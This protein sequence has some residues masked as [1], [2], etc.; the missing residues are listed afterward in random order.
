S[1]VNLVVIDKQPQLQYLSI[2]DAIDHCAR[3][4][5]VWEWAGNEDGARDPDII[6]ACAGDVVTMETVAA[7]QILAE[8]LPDLHTRVVNVVD[9]MALPRPKD[10]PH[11][12]DG[13][14]FT[15][16]FTDNVDVVFAFHGYPGAIHHLL[17]GRPETD[18]FHVRGF[19]EEGTTT[20]PFDMV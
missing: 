19:V 2:E 8:R 10:H 1:Y 9:L 12:L 20:T 14:T 13:T 5:S 18:R 3:G 17:H 7:A 15:E 11:G 6:L 4:A 16:L